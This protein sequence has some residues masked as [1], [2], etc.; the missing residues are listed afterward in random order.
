[1]EPLINSNLKRINNISDYDHLRGKG[2]MGKRII[3]IIQIYL[4]II[5]SISLISSSKDV[6]NLI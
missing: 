4:I 3:K 6:A 2:I 1:M 5:L